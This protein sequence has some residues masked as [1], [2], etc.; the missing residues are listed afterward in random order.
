MTVEEFEALDEEE[1]E[2]LWEE[3]DEKGK[4]VF[5][6]K[7]DSGGLGGG[8]EDSVLE[9]RGLFFV[10]SPDDR[11]P[12][13]FRSLREAIVGGHLTGVTS[14]VVE[15]VC[16]GRATENLLPLLRVH[17]DRVTLLINDE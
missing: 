11:P 2:E 17:D 10:F 4:E 1:Q 15:I 3:A 8:D 7:Y 14:A 16:E 5:S 9:H 12:G 13:P 6:L